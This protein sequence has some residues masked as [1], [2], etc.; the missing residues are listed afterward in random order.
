MVLNFVKPWRTSEML[1]G[2]SKSD[3]YNPDTEEPVMSDNER[4][5]VEFQEHLNKVLGMNQYKR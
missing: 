5:R 4:K 1:G 3:I 2:W